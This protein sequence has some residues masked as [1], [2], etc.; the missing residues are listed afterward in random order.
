MW[1]KNEPIQAF[2]DKSLKWLIED[3]TA[4][5]APIILVMRQQ[6]IAPLGSQFLGPLVQAF[7]VYMV[8]GIA[9]SPNIYKTNFTK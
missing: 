4:W 8:Y 3:I 5:I 1:M 9:E 2:F 7:Q 6:K